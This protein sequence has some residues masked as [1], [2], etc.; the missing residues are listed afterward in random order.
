MQQKTLWQRLAVLFILAAIVSGCASKPSF[1]SSVIE[2]PLPA[3]EIS[4]TDQNG[5][6]FQVSAQHGKVLLLFFGFSHCTNECPLT[7]ANIK[8]ALAI[9][10]DPAK[11]VTVAMVST[12]P[13]NDTAQSMKDFLGKFDPT[14]LG[15]LG[16]PDQ[17]AK[18]WKDY[19]VAVLDGG[20]THSSYT[21]VIDRKGDQRLIFSPDTTP[22]DIAHDV[23]ILLAEK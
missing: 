1:K 3:P 14:F 5:N 6:T 4:L 22:D 16:T 21:Y 15:I 9:I 23:K 10:G 17:L 20:E 19:G 11:D 2:P 18:A 7:M 8:A 13:A 12:D